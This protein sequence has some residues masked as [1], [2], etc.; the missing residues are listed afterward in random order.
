MQGSWNNDKPHYRCVYPVEYG[1]ANQT[2]HPRSI[3]LR[4]RWSSRR[5]TSG[6]CALSPTALPRT[7]QVLADAQDEPHD[8]QQ[9]AR[10]TNTV[11]TALGNIL[12]VLRDADPADKAKI[13]N[14]IGLKLTYQPARNAVI[15]E[16]TT[17]ATMY[18]GLSPR[19]DLNRNYMVI[20]RQELLLP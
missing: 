14:G 1:L 7:I 9:L 15:A 13:Y 2:Q 20:L 3:Y 19:R 12:D 18:E 10:T 5:W 4:E 8:H 11:I 17:P 6:Y 16:P